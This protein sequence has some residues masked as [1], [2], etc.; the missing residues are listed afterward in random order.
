ML[1]TCKTETTRATSSI[2]LREVIIEN[3]IINRYYLTWTLGGWNIFKHSILGSF[4]KQKKKK[5][6]FK[7]FIDIA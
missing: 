2:F 6:I 3:N 1:R 4:T 7:M 5:T